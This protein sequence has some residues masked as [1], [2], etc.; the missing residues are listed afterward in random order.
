MHWREMEE[1][2][3]KA[4]M[5]Q[6]TLDKIDVNIAICRGHKIECKTQ[7]NEAVRIRSERD[8]RTLKVLRLGVLVS[9][10]QL[11]IDDTITQVLSGGE[12]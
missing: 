2:R 6:E 4:K 12:L 7:F 11:R 3:E 9:M 8:L 10:G 5:D 1:I